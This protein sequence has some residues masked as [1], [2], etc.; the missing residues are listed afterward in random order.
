MFRRPWLN[1]E[2]GTAWQDSGQCR[3][4]R[5]GESLDG[6]PVGCV[7]AATGRVISYPGTFARSTVPPL[8]EPC[9]ELR[10]HLV[11]PDSP[12]P[13]SGRDVGIVKSSGVG[14]SGDGCGGG[15]ASAGEA[16]G[17]KVACGPGLGTG[18][19]A[20]TSAAAVAAH[21][22]YRAKHT[23]HLEGRWVDMG[24]VSPTRVV[25]WGHAPLPR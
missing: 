11:D 7:H 14:A 23:R 8:V 4:Y 9:R 17:P 10:F 3:V 1:V 15:G 12:L 25:R 21:H 19:E 16:R 20:E 13:C 2:V 24:D 6:V 22:A 18:D 5:D